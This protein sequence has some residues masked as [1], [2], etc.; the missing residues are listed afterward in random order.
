MSVV[1]RSWRVSGRVQGVG[2][3]YFVQRRALALGLRGWVRNLPDGAVEVAAA[4]AAEAVNLLAAALAEGP[5][6]ARV[7]QLEPLH[8]PS[9][10]ESARGF[11]IEY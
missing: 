8:P 6:H 7:D 3:R 5:A 2:F 9:N 1:V 11:T 4:G 10:L